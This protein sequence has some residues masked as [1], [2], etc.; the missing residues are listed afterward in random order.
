MTHFWFRIQP[1]EVTL[2]PFDAIVDLQTITDYS[3][4]SFRCLPN[5]P[6]QLQPKWKFADLKINIHRQSFLREC[7]H[8]RGFN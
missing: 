5:L 1:E 7:L 3:R 4:F 2:I 8:H 6:D